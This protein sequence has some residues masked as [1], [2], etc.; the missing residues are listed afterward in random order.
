[1]KNLNPSPVLRRTV[2]VT[3]WPAS[4]AGAFA[5]SSTSRRALTDA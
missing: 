1:M 4:W 3:A 2:F 5:I